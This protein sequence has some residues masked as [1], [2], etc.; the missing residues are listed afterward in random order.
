MADIISNNP[1]KNADG[2]T[3]EVKPKVNPFVTAGTSAGPV[4]E[5]N[6]FEAT[7]KARAGAPIP[8]RDE[9]PFIG[10]KESDAG[11][12][13]QA[14]NE[15]PLNETAAHQ[16]LL[17]DYVEKPD[18]FWMSKVPTSDFLS[19]LRAYKSGGGLKLREELEKVQQS[20][21]LSD[22]ERAKLGAIIE[23]LSADHPEIFEKA[24][25][26]ETTTAK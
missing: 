14:K 13:S 4:R 2:T 11:E 24:K 9:N 6:P 10:A 12:A 7:I 21:N 25:V 26:V 20:K 17:L 22:S 5:E 18:M 15:I 3:I 16:A 23:D 19:L 1:F 8:V